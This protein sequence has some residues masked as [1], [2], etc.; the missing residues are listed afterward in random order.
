MNDFFNDDFLRESYLRNQPGFLVSGYNK[1]QWTLDSSQ[2]NPVLLI[3]SWKA[4][5]GDAITFLKMR[6]KREFRK[7]SNENQTRDA[8]ALGVNDLSDYFKEFSSFEALLYGADRFY[9]DHIMHVF[10]VW[11]IGRW[12]IEQFGSD[13]HFDYIK[14]S[15]ELSISKDEIEAMWCIIALTHDLGYPLD[16]IDKIRQKIDSMMSY[17]GGTDSVG[18]NFQIPTHHHFINDFILRFISSKLIEEKND[19]SYRTSLQ[20]KFYLKFSR[21]FEKF[22]HGI[23]SCI[24]LMKNLVYFLES[25]LDL[26]GRPF[27]ESEDARQFFIRRD[28]MRSIASHTCTDIYHLYPNSLSFI[29]ILADELQVWGR[30]TFLDMKSGGQELK[31]ESRLSKISKKEI[32]MEFRI[33]V[34][35]PA[36][37][38]QYIHQLFGKWYKLLR[39]ALDASERQFSFIFS[40]EVYSQAKPSTS[41]LFSSTLENMITFTENGNP[42]QLA[43]LYQ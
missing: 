12:I 24:V 1:R 42:H 41:Y 27:K 32:K 23:I 33:E 34:D 39:S 2:R 22:E 25:D 5:L 13:I 4:L 3:D 28:I 29:L 16:K 11:L 14:D 35:G 31:V 15:E 19:N 43:E 40:I 8:I 37:V 26:G 20:S 17:F 9:R 30:P 6:D 36:E 21:S 10:R 38:K 7:S 18:G